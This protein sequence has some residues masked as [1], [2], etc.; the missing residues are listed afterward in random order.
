MNVFAELKHMPMRES[1]ELFMK[2]NY[3]ETKD[4]CKDFLTLVTG[5]LVF[6]LAFSEKIVD[7][8]HSAKSARVLLLSSWTLFMS[9]I[10]SCGIGLTYL[11]LAGGQA[12]YGNGDH[13]LD[14]ASK[15]YAW[16]VASGLFFILGLIAL[17][18]AGMVA[19]FAR[20]SVSSSV[21]YGPDVEA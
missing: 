5:I 7:F 9:T 17:V 13:Y 1:A 8:Q 11:A 3:A 12:V 16:V 21:E 18:L 10:I 4:L 19:T 20:S 15:C 2:Y 14:L 6:S